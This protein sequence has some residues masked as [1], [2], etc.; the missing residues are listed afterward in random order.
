MYIW[1]GYGGHR[2]RRAFYNDL[3]VLETAPYVRPLQTQ[4]DAPAPAYEEGDLVW[5]KVITIGPAP[6]PRSHH[7][8]SLI[9]IPASSDN[10]MLCVMGGRDHLKFFDGVH[11]LDLNTL[12]WKS[13]D[14]PTPSLPCGLA[15]HMAL[16]IA[17]V[18]HYKLFIFG[19][20]QGGD[21]RSDWKYVKNVN[22]LDCG[23]MQWMSS[24]E[25]GSSFVEGNFPEARED[26]AYCYDRRA[27]RVIIHGGWSQKFLNDALYLDVS[28]IVGPPYAIYELVPFEGPMTGQ[29]DIQIMGEDFTNGSIK[30]TFTDGK[31]TENVDGKYVSPTQLTCK[32]PSWEKYAAGEVKMRVNIRGEGLTVNIVKWTYYVNTNPKKCVAFGTGLFDSD[33][34]GWGFPAIFKVQAKDNSGRNRNTGGET[35]CWKPKAQ[36]LGPNPDY[37]DQDI[38]CRVDDVGD[39]TYDITYVPTHA[40]EYK[41]EVGYCDPQVQ[42]DEVVAVKGSPWTTSFEDPWT[43]VKVKEADQPGKEPPKARSGSGTVSL[44]KKVILFGGDGE[45]Q[46]DLV[47]FDP[48]SNSWERPEFDPS[49]GQPP[50]KRF[51]M[52]M[53]ALDAEKAV[54]IGGSMPDIGGEAPPSEWMNDVHLLLCEKG[55]WKWQEAGNVPGDLFKPR[56][57]HAACL[58][59]VGKKVV[60]FGGMTDEYASGGDLLDSCSGTCL[61]TV[62]C[63]RCCLQW[64]VLGSCLSDST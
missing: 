14:I 42:G 30:V 41:V 18:P 23:T 28:S 6:E 58:I 3:H 11:F 25:V 56:A 26:M 38:P 43:K 24:D 2:Q 54:I 29:T 61:P 17:S 34:C 12:E 47:C 40:G 13:L 46:D 7:S 45:E 59:P 8:T 63:S 19:G 32:S 64:G 37:V 52:T 49:E 16:A 20:Q 31:N 50:K 4:D 57:K 22:C 10:K 21:N 35:A 36:Y 51:G 55:H 60:V 9:A 27:G 53:T 44:A 15:H 48:D 39:G 33:N 62:V 1:G 5:T